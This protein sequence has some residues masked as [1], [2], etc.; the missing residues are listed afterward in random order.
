MR[1]TRLRVVVFQEGDWLCARCLEYDLGTQAR[2]LEDVLV[3]LQRIFLGHIAIC[4]ENELKPFSM[5]RRAPKKYWD[6][7]RRSRI[8]LP[9]QTFR[10]K[11]SRRGVKLPPPEIRVA[12]VA[13]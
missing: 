6:M 2:N 11:I 3:D 12:P 4:A 1:L 8:S 13:A 7:F 9:P 10:F 5:L